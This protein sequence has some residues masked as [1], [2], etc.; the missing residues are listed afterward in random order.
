MIKILRIPALALGS[1]ALAVSSIAPAGEIKGPPPNGNTSSPPFSRISNG[2]SWCSFSGLNDTP[3][4]TGQIGHPGYDPGGIAQSY[5][6]FLSQGLYDP[7]DP[8][9]RD[10]F[11]FPGVGC[12]PTRSIP[13][14]G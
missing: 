10:M 12:N 8:A 4:G 5:G 3:D 7:S 11:E 2:K 9:D 13:I 6:Y 14:P 1:A